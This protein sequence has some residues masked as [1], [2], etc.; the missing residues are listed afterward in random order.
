VE[1]LLP[2]TEPLKQA[3]RAAA[4]GRDSRRPAPGDAAELLWRVRALEDDL[5]RLRQ[6]QEELRR[7]LT[8][9]GQMQRRLCG[10]RRL[11]RGPFQIAGEIFPLEHLSGD[12]LAVF[13]R[14][15]DLVLAIGDIS[16]KGLSA[17]LWFT[18]VVG[19][20]RLLVGAQDDPATALTAINRELAKT[21]ME[22]ALTTV[23]LARLDP[24][25]GTLRYSNAGH[26]PALLLGSNGKVRPLDE[27]GPLLGALAAAR[28]T[29]QEIT[30]APG[31]ILLGYSDGITERVNSKGVEFGVDRIL[32]AAQRSR[33][34]S[35]SRTLF[36]ILGAVED[37]AG[38]QKPEDDIALLVLHRAR[39]GI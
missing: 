32:E 16:G 11:R 9:A 37:F 3:P 35:A 34:A 20:I 27:G 10:P 30:F 31:D 38:N 7:A 28:F 36:S 19:M 18:H 1:P 29:S 39:E 17:G 4:Q 13:E 24:V 15:N 5:D 33:G 14:E 25:A 26:P 6:E 12:F 8:E 2:V 22:S 23:F 21:E